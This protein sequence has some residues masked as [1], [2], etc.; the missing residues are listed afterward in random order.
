MTKRATRRRFL[1]L[2]SA[3]TLALALAG[4]PTLAHA[5][6]VEVLVTLG[7]WAL[8]FFVLTILIRVALPIEM[9]SARSP[10]LRSSSDPPVIRPRAPAEPPFPRKPIRTH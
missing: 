5:A 10:W 1:Q 2:A 6:E 3:G 7:V 8:G 4:T 9:G